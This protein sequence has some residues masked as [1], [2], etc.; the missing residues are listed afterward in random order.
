MDVKH[1]PKLQDRVMH[2]RNL[3][4]AIDRAARYL[5]LAV[6][7][8]ETTTSV[9][10]FQDEALGAFPFRVTHVLS[11]RGSCFRAD[12]F[13]A[14]CERH[15]ASHRTAKPYAPRDVRHGRAVQPACSARNAERR[16]TQPPRP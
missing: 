10:A 5:H 15:G 1:L 8:D 2:K 14:A 4:D 16:D 12:A 9:V 3:Y 13:E 7:D 6:N 11:G